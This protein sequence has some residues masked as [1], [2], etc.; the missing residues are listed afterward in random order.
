[1]CVSMKGSETVRPMPLPEELVFT[2]DDRVRSDVAHAKQQYFETVSTHTHTHTFMTLCISLVVRLDHCRC[3]VHHKH[4]V[5]GPYSPHHTHTTLICVISGLTDTCVCVSRLRT[6]RWCVMRSPR[7][8]KQPSNRGSST[9]TPSYNW[10][11]NWLITDSMGGNT[12]HPARAGSSLLGALSEIS[13]GPK[14]GHG[15]ER[16]YFQF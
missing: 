13:L 4:T 6:C 1:M 5:T 9:Q 7:L 16:H 12:I 2:V 14:L 8:G 10:P 3:C 11:F 15:V